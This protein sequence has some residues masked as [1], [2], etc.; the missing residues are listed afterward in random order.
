M[1]EP[2]HQEIFQAIKAKKKQFNELRDS[3]LSLPEKWMEMLGIIL[4]IQMEVAEKGGFEKGQ[5]GL[6]KFNARLMEEAG[7]SS[8]LSDEIKKRWEWLFEEAFGYRDIESL[9]NNKARALFFDIA[10]AM[11]S[12]A[13]LSSIIEFGKTFEGSVVKR[14]QALLVY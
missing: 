11:S 10:A 13:F 8:A 3:R 14:R 6:Q 5:R 1:L 4:P 2:L 7:A 12:E 9:G